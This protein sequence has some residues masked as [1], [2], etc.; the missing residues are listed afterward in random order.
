MPIVSKYKNEFIL[1]KRMH[2]RNN[3]ERNSMQKSK[4]IQ[5]PHGA[6]KELIVP[7]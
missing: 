1:V 7:V 3:L 6:L 4:I 2:D 5:T